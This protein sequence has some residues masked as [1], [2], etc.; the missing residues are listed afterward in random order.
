MKEQL[1]T[2][3]TAKLAKEKEFN[4]S[5]TV[6]SKEVYIDRKISNRCS[7]AILDDVILSPTQALLQKWLR[8][9]HNKHI[10]VHPFY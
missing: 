6:W 1:I 2:F 8:E 9:I 7:Y 10:N 3:E 5:F 4:K